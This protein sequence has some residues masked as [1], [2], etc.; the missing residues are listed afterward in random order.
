MAGPDMLATR[1]TYTP[2]PGRRLPAT[3]WCSTGMSAVRSSLEVL[4]SIP[5]AATLTDDSDRQFDGLS[6]LA[7]WA[8]GMCCRRPWIC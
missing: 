8:P 3:A 2:C 4:A 6:P 1:S 7:H 5:Q